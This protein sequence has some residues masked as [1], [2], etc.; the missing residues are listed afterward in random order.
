MRIA[1]LGGG[2][3][4]LAAAWDLGKRHDVTLF[5]SNSRTGGNIYTEQKDGFRIEWGP[6]GFLDN[7]PKT[8]ELVEELGLTSRLQRAQDTAAR[9]FIWREGKLREI[10]EKPWKFLFAGVLP[11]MGTLRV[12]LEPWSKPRPEHDE[13]VRDFAARHMGPQ[14]AD[15]MI[16]AFVTGV[17]A[18]DPNRLS[19]KSAFPKLYN[20][21]SE[22]GSLI[23]GAKGRG[24]GPKGYLTSFDH[25]LQVLVDELTSRLDVRLNEP[26][27]KIEQGDYDRVICSIPAH[28]AAPLVDP[29]LS[30]LLSKIPG[31]PLAV[32]AL[33]FEKSP[34]TP[35]AFGFL[36]PRNQGL[37]ML[38]C[39]YD[40]SIFK[41]RAP[42]GSRLFRIMLG[43]RR[44]PE[45]ADLPDEELLQLTLSE[46]ERVWGSVPEP[47]GHRIVRWPKG[48]SQY[49]I[50]H[51]DLVDEIDRNT[52]DWLKLTGSSYRG[53][54]MNLCVK[55]AL[56]GLD[57]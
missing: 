16:D 32:V 1:V 41:H 46:L 37:K 34:P 50:G 33:Q 31:G 38:G 13:S 55:E 23:K 40:S 22:Y 11:L 9:R 20:L 5:E 24:F 3:A 6:N 51:G 49:E 25:G 14:A 47:S 36:V 26:V 2:L 29:P 18:G 28:A 54:A 7:E 43:G 39:L 53:V 44:E 15:I 27:E 52:P 57:S 35:E 21:E 17:F 10:P 4:G 30:D 56:S 48:I 19:V 42:D 12:A 8:L 45:V